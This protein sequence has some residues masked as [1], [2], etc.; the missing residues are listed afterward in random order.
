MLS[1]R[2]RRYNL[3]FKKDRSK[4]PETTIDHRFGLCILH[5]TT[6]ANVSHDTGLSDMRLSV[7]KLFFFG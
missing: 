4:K 2:G 5:V 3:S 1:E 6:L 7:G